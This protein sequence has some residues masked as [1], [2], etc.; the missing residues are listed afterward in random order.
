MGDIVR[1]SNDQ[2]HQ[3]CKIAGGEELESLAHAASPEN[4]RTLYDGIYS[5]YLDGT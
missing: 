5:T 3:W 4:R 1:Y 2:S